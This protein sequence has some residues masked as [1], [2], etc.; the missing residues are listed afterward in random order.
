MKKFLAVVLLS[1]VFSIP[2]TSESKALE[3]S[4]EFCLAFYEKL[5][6]LFPQ[7]ESENLRILAKKEILNHFDRI[8]SSEERDQKFSKLVSYRVSMFENDSL[9]SDLENIRMISQA[10]KNL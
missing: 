3:V 6:S 5:V 10:C 1:G 7:K 9:F 8:F 4:D 2:C